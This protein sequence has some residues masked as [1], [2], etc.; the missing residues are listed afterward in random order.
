[1]LSSRD[2]RSPGFTCD[3][4]GLLHDLCDASSFIAST[5]D[6]ATAAGLRLN[7]FK[8]HLFPFSSIP[9]AVWEWLVLQG[10]DVVAYAGS[11]TL[12]GIH[13]SPSLPPS[14]RFPRLLFAMVLRCTLW[15]FRDCTLL[16]Q[17]V[18]LRTI[19]LSLLWY[20]AAVTPVPTSVALQVK[21]LCKSF[22]FK[23]SISSSRR[24]KGPM[25]EE[26][27]HRPTSLGGLGIADPVAFSSALQLCSLRDAMHSVSASHSIPRWFQ[28][29]FQLFNDLL[30]Y[31]GRGFDIFYA[32]IPRGL[33]LQEPWFGLRAFW[34][35]PLRA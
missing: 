20:T 19:V 2:Y 7:V 32:P 16:G 34:I 1:M 26:W 29:A 35:G 15:R 27:L 33:T 12:L 24:I 28:P 10:W 17:A 8:T 13:V 3:C 25:E 22:L 23:K 31:G 21:R 4:T 14:S 9:P 6:Y 5:R 11:F 30:V 18:I